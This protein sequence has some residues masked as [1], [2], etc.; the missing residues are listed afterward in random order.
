[1]KIRNRR[2]G[3]S[4]FHYAHFLYDCLFP[5][6]NKK[7][8]DMGPIVYRKKVLMQTIG[9]FSKIYEEVMGVK[10]VEVDEKVFK[11][12]K[13]KNI[14]VES[15]Y[16]LPSKREFDYFRSYVLGRYMVE[17]DQSFPQV[18]LIER[19]DRRELLNDDNLRKVNNNYTT[20]KERREIGRIGE[21]KEYLGRLIPYV[22]KV[23]MLEDMPFGEQ[24]KLFYNVK[25]VIAAHGAAMT[26]MLFSKEGMVLV[27]V[28]EVGWEWKY[29]DDIAKKCGIRLI[30]VDNNLDK[31]KSLVTSEVK[32]LKISGSKF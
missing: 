29:F 30:K 7:V 25:M 23:V 16:K 21:L 14:L 11:V 22:F 10:N 24:V 9:N 4:L 12:L 2:P 18:I 13:E 26:N 32:R 28:R 17:D 1:V 5:E 15:R 31:I 20:G 19:G 6:V 3:G 27:E 8:Y